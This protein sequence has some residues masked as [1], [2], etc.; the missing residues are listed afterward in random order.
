MHRRPHCLHRFQP[1]QFGIDAGQFLGVA[2]AEETPA[3]LFGDLAQPR[4]ID[5]VIATGRN[6]HAEQRIPA[7][8]AERNRV[9]AHAFGLGKFG[10]FQWVEHAG[11]VD[12]IGEQHYHAL[13]L[14]LLAQ[15]FDRQRNR[16]ADR[17]F[18]PGQAHHAVGQLIADRGQVSGQRRQRIGALAEHQQAD[19]IAFAAIQKVRQ[20]RLGRRQAID[21]AAAEHHI[22]LA[23]AAGQIHRQHHLSRLARRLDHLA[24]LLRTRKRRTQQ[25]PAQP[26]QPARHPQC[27][28]TLRLCNR[29]QLIGVGHAQRSRI[30]T[31]LR[32]E[33]HQ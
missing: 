1:I 15:P 19:T 6:R 4:F 3:G 26:C 21:D 28:H 17:G 27:R 33:P 18:A 7:A 2:C 20:H 32:P 31:P 22:R 9:H 12:A 13:P 8:A 5:I 29:M 10:G 24:Q 25:E 16:I 23:H 30:G 11:R 14:F